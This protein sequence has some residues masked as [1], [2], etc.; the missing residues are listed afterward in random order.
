MNRLSSAEILRIGSAHT[1]DVEP[2][3]IARLAILSISLIITD[4]N[5]LSAI[6][7]HQ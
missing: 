7:P 5:K 2:M 1:V 6:F 4:I 3:P